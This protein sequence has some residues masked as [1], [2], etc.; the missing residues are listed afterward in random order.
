MK[1]SD[2]KRLNIG[3]KWS[4]LLSE[5]S[6]CQQ[7]LYGYLFGVVLSSKYDFVHAA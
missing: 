7:C 6:L 4:L 1:L 2:D 3:L 5:S